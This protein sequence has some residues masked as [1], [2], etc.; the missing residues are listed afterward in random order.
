MHDDDELKRCRA[1]IQRLQAENQHLRQSAET[2]GYLAERLS[3]ELHAE[4]RLR[5]ADRRQTPNDSSDR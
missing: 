2:F 4:R 3:Q 5:T 1:E